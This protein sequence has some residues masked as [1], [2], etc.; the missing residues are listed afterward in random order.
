MNNVMRLSEPE[1]F[2]SVAAQMLKTEKDKEEMKHDE[3]LR[4]VMDKHTKE[5][6][7]LGLYITQV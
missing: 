7:D 3:E 4:E 6:H 5:T 1:M 2:A